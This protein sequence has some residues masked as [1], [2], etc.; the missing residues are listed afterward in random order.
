MTT[1]WYWPTTAPLGRPCRLDP[2]CVLATVGHVSLSHILGYGATDQAHRAVRGVLSQ[3]VW[4]SPAHA[5]E[6]RHRSGTDNPSEMHGA[7]RLSDRRRKGGVF[8]G[9][10]DPGPTLLDV[11]ER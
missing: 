6:C 9:E 4:Y 7:G 2:T 8:T 3:P 5:T 11:V 1:T 10:L